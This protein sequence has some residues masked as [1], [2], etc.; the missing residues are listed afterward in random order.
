M[1][2]EVSRPCG[3]TVEP[4]RRIYETGGI[5]SDMPEPS[6]AR[7]EGT[8]PKLYLVI[9]GT[10]WRVHDADYRDGGEVHLEE[11]A[12]P[13]ALAMASSRRVLAFTTIVCWTLIGSPLRN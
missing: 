4:Y 10:P 12:Q 8:P 6:A 3:P 5:H 9:D 11:P 13:S 2:T 1:L 7:L